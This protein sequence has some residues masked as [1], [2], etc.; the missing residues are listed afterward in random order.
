MPVRME[1]RPKKP[2]TLLK[3]TER[4]II[5]TPVRRDI[6]CRK[7]W[8][9]VRHVSYCSVELGGEGAGGRNCSAK[10]VP[11]GGGP[12][13]ILLEIPWRRLLVNNLT[14]GDAKSD[15]A[16]GRRQMVGGL[17]EGVC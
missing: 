4:K 14:A 12:P 10:N 8:I 1:R 3:I 7:V 6:K 2:V 16:R 13:D 11:L 17:G 5:S 15:E 9:E